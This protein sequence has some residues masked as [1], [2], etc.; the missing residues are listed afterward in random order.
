MAH[1]LQTVPNWVPN[2]IN[3]QIL[4]ITENYPSNPNAINNNTFFYR[5]LNPTI[6]INCGNNLLNNLC[7]VLNISGNNEGIKL[8]NF[9]HLR[10]YFLIDTFPYGQPMSKMLIKQTINN[11]AWIDIVL[12]DI[13]YINPNQIVFTCVGSNGALLP[14][15]LNRARQRGLHILGNVVANT[16]GNNNFVFHSPSNRAFPTFMH[17]IQFAI[18]NGSLI[19]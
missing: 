6:A 13:L 17:Q 7:N 9:L 1:P 11:P 16:I 12:D 3:P 2:V 8:N 14:I 19:P 4:F 15:L 10:N 5:S 18:N